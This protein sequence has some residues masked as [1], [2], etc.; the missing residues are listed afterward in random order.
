[1][2]LAIKD[3]TR[4]RPSNRCAKEHRGVD[5]I[6]DVPFGRLLYGEQMQ[7][8]AQSRYEKLFKFLKLGVLL[9]FVHNP[10]RSQ[11]PSTTDHFILK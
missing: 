10:D 2:I 7:S 4:H 6:S 9:N 8:R 3:E 1:L 5:L 11:S